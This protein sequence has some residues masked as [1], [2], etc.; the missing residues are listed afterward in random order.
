M[1]TSD[2]RFHIAC[3]SCGA[4]NR[5][6]AGRAGDGPVCGTCKQPLFI[7]RPVELTEA[8]FD[9]DVGNPH[10]APP[11]STEIPADKRSRLTGYFRFH[12][13][14]GQPGQPFP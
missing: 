4:V 8:S 13:Q 3:P 9:V 2:D 5:V 11:G 1:T 14:R 6:A 7:G 12:F 10:D